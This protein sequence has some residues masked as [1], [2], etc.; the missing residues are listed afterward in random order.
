MC[1]FLSFSLSLC[2]CVC[3]CVCP[4]RQRVCYSSANPDIPSSFRPLPPQPHSTS[5]PVS[6]SVHNPPSSSRVLCLRTPIPTPLP[7]P[8]P[9]A[10][11]R[12]S[13]P[14]PS[15][16]PSTSSP[17]PSFPPQRAKKHKALEIITGAGHHSADHRSHIGPEVIKILSQKHIKFTHPNHNDGALQ[18]IL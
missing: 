8:P 17:P 16:S 3:V 6:I 7:L 1:L 12:R 15:L 14:S 10:L 9:R 2:V 4:L 11:P 18:L 5:I 13:S